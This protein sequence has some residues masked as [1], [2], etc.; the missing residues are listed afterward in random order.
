MLAAVRMRVES[1]AAQEELQRLGSTVVNDFSDVF[2][3][4]PHTHDL[5]TDVYCTIA[6][7]DASKTIR[8]RTY[9]SPRKYREALINEHLSARESNSKH[10]SPAFLIPKSD[11][12]AAP[13]WV[14]DYWE[15]NA[16]W[17]S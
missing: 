9:S 7:K 14:N 11:P 5:P 1:L 4:I 2:D 12:N 16:S 10:A 8:T 13:R 3:P 6:L 15:L 17:I